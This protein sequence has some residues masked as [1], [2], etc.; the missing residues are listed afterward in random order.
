[1]GTKIIQNYIKKLKYGGLETNSRS[2]LLNCIYERN[3]LR[4]ILQSYKNKYKNLIKKLNECIFEEN[5]LY[6][7][8]NNENKTA[9]IKIYNLLVVLNIIYNSLENYYNIIICIIIMISINIYYI[10]HY[11][12]KNKSFFP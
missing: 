11:E 2:E 1:M 6:K 7:I 4:I 9:K 12:C 5:R 3:R 8:Y 10:C